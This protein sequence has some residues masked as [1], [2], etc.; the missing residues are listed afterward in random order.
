VIVHTFGP[1]EAHC[2][3]F[4]QSFARPGLAIGQILD[5][6][7]F[8]TTKLVETDSFR[9]VRISPAARDED[10]LKH[11]AIYARALTTFL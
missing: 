8:G 7:D 11:V 5:M 10:P 1:V 3:H 9:H 2:F 6:K 4:E